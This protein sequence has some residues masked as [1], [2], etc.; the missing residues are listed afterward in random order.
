MRVKVLI[1]WLLMVVMVT[2]SLSGTVRADAAA[3]REYRLKAA[4]LHSF[5]MFVDGGRFR[6]ASEP[7]DPA[8]P[9]ERIRIGIVGPSPFGDAFEPLRN[10]RVKDRF[11]VVTYIKGLSQLTDEDG[12]SP[13]EHPQIEA[14]RQCHMLFICASEKPHIGSLLNP[15]RTL[16]ILTVADTPGFL[17]AGGI[18]N[19]VIED[20]KVRFEVNTAAAGRAQLQIRARLLRLAQ[21]VVTH[22]AI[23][24]QNGEGKKTEPADK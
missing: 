17:E 5:M 2:M 4:F 8:D 11:V 20:K 22:D 21:R 18:I 1:L 23:E 15:I 7:K 13:Q 6:W 24:E 12:H 16:G 9:N 19:F 10:R 14:M 3:S